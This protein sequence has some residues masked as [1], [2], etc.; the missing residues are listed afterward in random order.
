MAVRAE[1][2]SQAGRKRADRT[3]LHV[4]P[5]TLQRARTEH[6]NQRKKAALPARVPVDSEDFYVSNVLIS[7]S[8][9]QYAFRDSATTFES[10]LLRL[11]GTCAGVAPGQCSKSVSRPME[12]GNWSLNSGK[13]HWFL[14]RCR[15]WMACKCFV[16]VGGNG[17]FWPNYFILRWLRQK[18]GGWGM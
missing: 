18:K 17:F 12:C 5:R 14:V 3:K 15:S 10:L 9:R 1:A 6:E 2:V 4:A 16:S 11:R 7:D 8:W 13:M